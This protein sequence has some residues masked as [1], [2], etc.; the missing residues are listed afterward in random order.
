MEIPSV[1]RP[2]VEASLLGEES[3]RQALSDRLKALA[4][5]S[6]EFDS[7]ENDFEAESTRFHLAI[8]LIL[9][10]SIF[11]TTLLTL[12]GLYYLTIPAPKP[13]VTTQDGQIYDIKNYE[14]VRK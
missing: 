12:G 6:I 8:S 9:W 10:I 11:G 14:S 3:S 2:S 7:G 4:E 13:Y 1:S 5:T